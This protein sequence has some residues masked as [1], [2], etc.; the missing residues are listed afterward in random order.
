MRL[1]A[2]EMAEIIIGDAR[3]CMKDALYYLTSPPDI[4]G[5][6]LQIHC[7]IK[8]LNDLE[9]EIRHMEIAMDTLKKKAEERKNEQE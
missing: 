8:R 4:S 6:T 5:A 9:E 2:D 3:G 1:P 7:A